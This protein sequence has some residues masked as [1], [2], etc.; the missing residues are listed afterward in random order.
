VAVAAFAALRLADAL[1][2]VLDR[3]LKRKQFG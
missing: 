3:F 1:G 2:Q